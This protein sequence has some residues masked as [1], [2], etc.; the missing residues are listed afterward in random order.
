VQSGKQET[1]QAT[2][3][4]LLRRRKRQ[5]VIFDWESHAGLRQAAST[6]LQR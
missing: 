6:K 3:G 5:R 4:R 2:S 1:G